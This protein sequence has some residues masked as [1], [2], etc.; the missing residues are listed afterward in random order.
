MATTFTKDLFSTTYKDDY[1]DSDNF[2]RILFNSGR[3]LQARELTQL[4]TIIQ[5]EI[6]RFGRNIF[7]EGASVNPGGQTLNTSYEFIKLDTTSISLPTNPEQYYGTVFTG[8]NSSVK[9]RLLEFKAAY[10]LNPATVYVQYTST[11]GGTHGATPVR[12]SPGEDFTNPAGATFR[13][14]SVNTAADPATGVGSKFSIAQGDFFT[15]GH[16]VRC[17]AQSIILEPFSNK[18]TKTVGFRVVQ[19]VVT[20]TDDN[21]LYDNQGATP[22]TS[23]PGADRYRIN[24][25]LTTE[26]QVTGNDNFVYYCRVINGVIFDIV[27]G[28]DEYNKI[29]DNIARRTKEIHGNFFTKPFICS[30]END[31]E[32]THLVATVGAGTAYVNGYRAATTYTSRIRVPKATTTLALDNEISAA[33]YGNFVRVKNI[34]GIPD[35]RTYERQ[36]LNNAITYGGSTIGTARVRAIE[37]DGAIQ[38]YFLFDV[39]MN[40]GQAFTSVKSIGRSAQQHADMC[41]VLDSNGGT[42]E[43]YETDKNNLFFDLKYERPKQFSDILLTVQRVYKRQASGGGIV[44]LN[45]GTGE[46]FV[47]TGEWFITNDANGSEI[48][49]TFSFSNNNATVDVGNLGSGTNVTIFAKVRRSQGQV[50]TKTLNTRSI[51]QQSFDSAG[52]LKF[53]NLGRSDIFSV[54]SIRDSGP[55]GV[56]LLSDYLIDN[57]QRDN[58]YG[59]GRVILKGDKGLPP[60]GKLYVGYRHFTHNTGDFFSSQSYTGVVDYK[61]IPAHT[62]NNGTTIQLRNVLDFRPAI[63]SNDSNF[64]SALINNL[65]DPTDVIDFDAE[66]YLPRLDRLVIDQDGLIRN[67]R[68]VPNQDPKLPELANNEMLL[69]DVRLNANTLHDSDISLAHYE[70]KMFTM[71]DVGHMEAKLDQL[72]EFTTLSLLENG[73][74]NL[75]TL[76]SAGNDRTKAGFLVDNFKDHASSDINNVE[77]RA[78]IDPLNKELRPSI[79]EEAIRLMYDSATSTRTVRRGDNVYTEYADSSW[80]SQLQASG[81]ENINPFAVITGMGFMELSPASDD[82]KESEKVAETVVGGG[83]INNFSGNQTQLFNNMEW[84]WGGTEIGATRSQIVGSTVS[85]NQGTNTSTSSEETTSGQWNSVSTTTSSVTTTTTTT[86]TA[87]A[88]AR[89][90]SFSTIRSVIGTRVVDVAVIP[91]MRSRAVWFRAQGLEPETKYTPFF[92]GI[93]V[94][95]WVRYTATGQF[96]MNRVSGKNNEIGD[97]YTYATQTPFGTPATITPL[98]SDANGTLEGEFFIPNGP[99]LKFKTGAREFK[100]LNITVNNENSATSMA[101]AIFTSQ[102]VI[103]N[104]EENVL[105]TRVRNIVTGTSISTSS[106]S[107]VSGRSDVTTTTQRNLITGE[108]RVDGV[109][110]VPPETVTQ[111]DP[112]AQSFFVS[113][114]DGVFLTKVNL[115]FATKK[116]AD[117]I[118]DTIVPVQLQ[119]RPMVN[120]HPSSSTVVPGSVIFKPAS[121]I[122]TS[123]DASQLTEFMFEEPV[124]LS[125]YT[126]YAVVLLAETTAYTVY[127]AQTEEFEIGSSEKRITSQPAMGSLFKSQNGSTWSA[128]QTKDL[129][130]EIMRASFTVGTHIATLNNAVVPVRLLEQNPATTISGGTRIQFRHPNHGFRTTDE[131]AIYG[132]DSGTSYAGISGA[133]INGLRVIDSADEDHFT[134]PAGNADVASSTSSIGGSNI[135]TSQNYMFEQVFPNIETL[136]PQGTSIALNGRFTNGRSTASFEMNKALKNA[137]TGAAQ[138]YGLD[139]GYN[140]PLVLRGQNY[141][142]APKVIHS[143]FIGGNAAS[144]QVTMTTNNSYV[145]PVLDM[146]RASLWLTHN[147]ID[148]Q[149]ASDPTSTDDGF[150]HPIVFQMETDPTGGT[151]LA[152]HITRPITLATSAVGLRALL[153]VHR[154]SVAEVKLYYKVLGVA[155]DQNFEDANWVYQAPLKTMPS[156]ENPNVFRE[157]EFLIGDKGGLAEPFTRFQLK[158]VMNSQNNAK[159]PKVK[160]MRIIALVT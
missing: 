22:N 111:V 68:G 65:P 152:K 16:F 134:I 93:D 28:K 106:S 80:I 73:I 159:P 58:F 140:T 64:T 115:Y 67:K 15:Q 129:K 142:D 70:T 102:G 66:Y 144:I 95:V 139:A 155:G 13:V 148:N 77:Y 9:V 87:S 34:K 156:D 154:P 69:A 101:K 78:S 18:P 127:I 57:G 84:N 143:P 74:A 8:Q 63:D 24:L 82:W 59:Q 42:V 11:T 25:V 30:Y 71:K 37:K 100:V 5:K 32:N 75:A 55:E 54:D 51:T 47:S 114:Q 56:D 36:F 81:T 145:S 109:T 26:D 137:N 23:A 96:A 27:S 12:M 49:A 29:E 125:A 2:H 132:F 17:K 60:S 91:F 83:T 151:S 10:D 147:R 31:S 14:Q 48:S 146:Q 43:L 104:M 124:Y 41:D 6:E 157:Y 21:D 61:D 88:V 79:C 153:S 90:D 4:Q 76:D 35:L 92:D 107:R 128:D 40:A 3:A 98:V 7:K 110:T 39:K 131:V 105:S 120:G 136:I 44:Q 94:S 123:D 116:E 45:G 46:T 108:I 158:L 53:V 119:I 62:L 160:D 122:N 85:E 141:F 126:E 118:T 1:E 103:E 33:D 50:R 52:D 150:N 113:E 112:L 19:D 86:Q 97:Q 130:F 72:Y 38:K 121:G 117:G 133:N 99:S 89:V 135:K 138:M 149:A 20:V